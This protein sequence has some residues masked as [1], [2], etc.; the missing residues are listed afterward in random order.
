MGIELDPYDLSIMAK[1]LLV[2]F[3]MRFKS[4]RLV[5]YK[6]NICYEGIFPQGVSYNNYGYLG[7]P[8]K[9]KNV[10]MGYVKE[11]M[12]TSPLG[13]A[14]RFLALCKH[15]KRSIGSHTLKHLAESLSVDGFK[16]RYVPNGVMVAA[17]LMCNCRIGMKRDTVTNIFI[18]TPRRCIGA[19]VGDRYNICGKLFLP[20]PNRRKRCFKCVDEGR[21]L[22]FCNNYKL[23]GIS[24]K[25]PTNLRYVELFEE[26][27]PLPSALPLPHA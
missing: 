13:A 10:M 15:S 3:D 7:T 12:S 23:D 22:G 14:L 26:I 20:N 19:R 2:D 11:D 25:I 6:Y 4:M 5:L 8:T 27:P 16:S 24:V 1:E 17:A 21:R 9:R 18:V